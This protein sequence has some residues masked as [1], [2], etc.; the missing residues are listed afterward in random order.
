[1]NGFE[2]QKKITSLPPNVSFDLTV[3]EN[4]FRYSKALSQIDSW[5]SFYVRTNFF[6]GAL[7]EQ[8]IWHV[9]NSLY[10]PESWRAWKIG[11]QGREIG[12]MEIPNPD[13][14]RKMQY[15]IID[16]T[17]PHFVFL[18]KIKAPKARPVVLVGQLAADL[19]EKLLEQHRDKF[20]H[21]KSEEHFQKSLQK[22]THPVIVA[23]GRK[24]L[25]ELSH[26]HPI[27]I[28]CDPRSV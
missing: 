15:E 22:R 1:M 3:S 5:D 16:G 28:M 7:L 26:L 27:V 9:V 20:S 10:T 24:E 23:Q 18:N 21:F 25:A 2:A 8:G 13:R 6:I 19:K 14:V 17:M 11:D 12:L 4:K